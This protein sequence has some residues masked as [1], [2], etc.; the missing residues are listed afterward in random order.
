M[1]GW[2]ILAA[3][4][5][6]LSGLVYLAWTDPKRRRTHDLPKI[7]RRPFVWPARIA[8]FGPGVYL[9]IIGHWSGLAIWAGAV[10]T[11]GW[12][13]AAITPETYANL[14]EDLQT[15]RA[16]GWAKAQQMSKAALSLSAKYIPGRVLAWRIELP[17]LAK[18]PTGTP[19]PA[20]DIE[21]LKARVTALEARLHRLE[22]RQASDVADFEARDRI[23]VSVG[24][25]QTDKPLNAAK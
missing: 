2:L 19:K 12:I 18:A 11:L 1:S 6:S 16:S 4:L 7:A 8:T 22:D 23:V 25:N 13:M 5:T 20:E 21:D 3:I 10:T 14:R 24:E 15:K 17:V 9:T